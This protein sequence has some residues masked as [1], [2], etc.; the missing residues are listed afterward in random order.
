MGHLRLMNSI[1][2]E[3]DCKMEMICDILDDQFKKALI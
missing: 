2:Q 1:V 3:N